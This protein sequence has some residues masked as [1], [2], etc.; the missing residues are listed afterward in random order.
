MAKLSLQMKRVVAHRM[1]LSGQEALN[2]IHRDRYSSLP[3]TSKPEPQ[4]ESALTLEESSARKQTTLWLWAF[5]AQGQGMYRLYRSGPFWSRRLRAV[6]SLESTPGIP[7]RI[8]PLNRAGSSN[9][10]TFGRT[11]PKL[12]PSSPAKRRKLQPVDQVGPL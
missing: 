4:P 5:L 7:E 1:R 6:Q 3:S 8:N 12:Q 2:H 9:T 10:P 11:E